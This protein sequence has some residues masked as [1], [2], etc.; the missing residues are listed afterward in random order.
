MNQ[1]NTGSSFPMRSGWDS[2]RR[3]RWGVYTAMDWAGQT[4]G[5][6]M[7]RRTFSL[8]WRVSRWL[9]SRQNMNITIREASN[10]TIHHLQKE[11]SSFEI[12]SKLV[13]SA[14][15]GKINY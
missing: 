13:L 6:L 14:E 8:W 15:N 3:I 11:G 5:W 2:S 1:I 7:K 12:N 10:N 9:L 4:K